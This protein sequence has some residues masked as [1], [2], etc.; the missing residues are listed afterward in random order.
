MEF[1]YQLMRN[2]SLPARK[3]WF[4]P[5]LIKIFKHGSNWKEIKNKPIA[6]ALKEITVGLSDRFRK[7]EEKPTTSRLLL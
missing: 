3:N 4:D 1:I 7:I 2:T 5:T 6:D